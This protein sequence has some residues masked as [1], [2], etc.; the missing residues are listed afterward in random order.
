MLN[1]EEAARCPEEGVVGVV[2]SQAR[3]LLSPR[4]AVLVQPPWNGSAKARSAL[5][6]LR[7]FIFL[8]SLEREDSTPHPRHGGAGG[9]GLR[10]GPGA[11]CALSV[12]AHITRS[13]SPQV[14]CG[15]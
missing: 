4:A 15:L 12:T 6:I 2:S 11:W 7:S 3:R 10:G 14:L 5:L 9:R 8:E 1:T 13:L